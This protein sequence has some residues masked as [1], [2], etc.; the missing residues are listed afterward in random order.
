MEGFDYPSDP[1]T[2][3]QMQSAPSTVYGK[4]VQGEASVKVHVG[5]PLP[6]RG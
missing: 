4:E 2:N 6:P 1:R 5:D 3:L